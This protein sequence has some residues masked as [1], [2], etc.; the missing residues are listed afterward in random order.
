MGTSCLILATALWVGILTSISP[1]PLATNI[2]AMSYLAKHVGAPRM[3]VERG[4]LYSVGRTLAY[5]ILAVIFVKSAL[6]SPRV[7]Q[8]IQKVMSVVIGPLLIFIACFLLEWVR[9]PSFSLV[10]E[11][12]RIQKWAERSGNLGALLLGFV[13]AL[14]FCPVSAGLFFGTLIPLALQT[15]SVFFVPALYGLGSAMPVVAFALVLVFSAASLGKIFNVMTHVEKWARTIT[16]VVFFLVGLFLMW[17]SL[18]FYVE[19]LGIRS[20]MEGLQ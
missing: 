9:L 4:V 17:R 8:V 16:A 7:A 15:Q 11:S 18:P 20:S 1:C 14:T 10:G 6:S 5:I 13:F 12:E 3:A 2:A 19:W